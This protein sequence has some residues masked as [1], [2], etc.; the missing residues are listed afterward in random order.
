[1]A[2]RVMSLG[3]SGEPSRRQKSHQDVNAVGPCDVGQVVVM[4]GRLSNLRPIGKSACREEATATLTAPPLGGVANL[5][6]PILAPIPAAAGALPSRY[7]GFCRKRRSRQRSS[8]AR[9]DA[10]RFA[11]EIDTRKTAAGSAGCDESPE[12]GR[13]LPSFGLVW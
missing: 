6:K 7:A 12:R 10:L 13:R 8:V 4:W 9:V 2:G 1:M 11:R 5:G 3:D